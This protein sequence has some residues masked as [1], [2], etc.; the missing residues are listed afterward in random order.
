MKQALPILVLVLIVLSLLP[1]PRDN[2]DGAYNLISQIA[3]CRTR[4]ACL[5]EIGH[6]LDQQAGWVSASPEFYKSL[7]MYLYVEIHQQGITELPAGILEI[8]YR[9]DGGSN[10]I[11]RELYAYLF[12]QAQGNSANMPESLR[13]F[14]DWAAAQKYLLALKQDKFFYRMN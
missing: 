10:P 13:K 3:W 2:Q 14:Y 12:Q 9:G 8:T 11:K 1:V 5:H 6:A 4:P 7:Q